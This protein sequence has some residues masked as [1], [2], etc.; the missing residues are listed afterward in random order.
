MKAQAK[1]SA[2]IEEK[3]KIWMVEQHQ[4]DIIKISKALFVMVETIRKKKKFT[5]NEFYGNKNVT[6]MELKNKIKAK[7]KC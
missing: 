6:L 2:K 5:P 4:A 7:T 1:L 3:H